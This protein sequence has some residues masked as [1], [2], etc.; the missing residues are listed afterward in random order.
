MLKIF[1]LFFS[2]LNRV[3]EPAILMEMTLRNGKIYTFEVKAVD[4]LSI[5]LF[6]YLYI[7]K[8]IGHL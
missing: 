6:L 8:R 5:D 1:H 3:L 4:L 7:Y 2:V